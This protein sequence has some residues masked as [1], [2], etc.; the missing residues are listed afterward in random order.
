M[1]EINVG[2]E[3]ELPVLVIG[4][5]PVGLA[6]A[7]ELAYRGI[8]CML[9][10][11]GDGVVRYSKMG[12]VSVRSMEHC[13]RWGVAEAVR[14]CGFPRDYPLS[15]VF[16]TS[17]NGHHI[18]TLPY[19][20]IEEESDS[21]EF[22]PE[23]KQRC[24]QLWF[25]PIL[26]QAAAA[27]S[28]ITLRYQTRLQSF[29]QG[30]ASVSAEL[31]DVNTGQVDVVRARYLVGCDG[32]GSRV[33][34]ALGIE[35]Q[36]DAALSYSVGIY[37]T[38]PDLAKHHRMGL[39]SRYWMI[40]E[41]GTW[42][43][44]TV[45]DAKD[46]WRLTITGGP[47]RVESKDFDSQYWLNRC[48]GNSGI[49]YHIDA[50]LPWRRSRLLANA[51]GRGRVFLA[52]DACHVNAPNGGYG[53][54][55]GVGDAVDL[56]WK[57][58]AV[59]DGWAPPQLLQTY[60]IE[61]RPVGRRSVDAAAVNFARTRPKVDYTH[62]EEDSERGQAAR[63]E[64]AE[65][66]LNGTRQ[67]WETLG[68]HLGYAYEDSPIVFTEPEP[69]PKDD[70]SIY[71]PTA[72]P[73]HR[74]PHFFLNDGRSVIDLFGHGFVLLDMSCAASPTQTGPSDSLRQAWTQA[75][76]ETGVPF[77][78]H[79]VREPAASD[80]YKCRYALVRPDGHVAWRGDALD[81]DPI[82]ILRQAIG[83]NLD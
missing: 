38:A 10:D 16:C 1:N 36:G 73:G 60:E 4:A 3:V 48:L 15:Q 20:S 35:L 31:V 57:L 27:Q 74:A 72:R 19:P 23:H 43:N 83:R 49:P 9:V 21:F 26:A 82:S 47:E 11:Q 42:G 69:R 29:D 70:L 58:A 61:R 65:D 50:V 41:E 45:V 75:A 52:G 81:L 18:G 54:N 30:A 56:G 22:S 77:S 78:I 28:L 2:D 67:E 55:T 17:L 66:M 46:I 8:K 7:L 40:G 33:R 13:R 64:V 12:H 24:P 76:T 25:D 32:A 63:A 34:Q 5:G 80:L 79:S 59:I 37:F 39:G 62:V 53:M 71:T 68:V 6:L 51:Y 44:L 14:N